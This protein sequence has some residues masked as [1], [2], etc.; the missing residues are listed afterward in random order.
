MYSKGLKTGFV[1]VLLTLAFMPIKAQPFQ[2]EARLDTNR[3][4]IGDQIHLY[5]MLNQP[6]TAR[7]E[8]PRWQQRISAEVEVIKSFP[9]DTLRKGQEE[10][11]TVRQ[12]YLITSFDSGAVKIPPVSFLYK[13]RRGLDSVLTAPL[14]LYVETVRVD[15]TQNIFGIKGPFGAPLSWS[16][17]LPWILGA[18][19][20]GLILWAV[21]YVLRRRKKQ[22]PL[23]K[24]RK[25][26]EPAHEYA[27]RELD[28]LK[29]D[30]LWQ[31]DQIKAYYT[32]LT[33]I[34]RTYLWMRYGIKTLERTTE[35]ILSSLNNSEMDDQAAFSLLA[36]NLRFADLVKF[37]RMHPAPRENEASLQQAYDFVHTTKHIPEDQEQ[38]KGDDD[39]QAGQEQESNTKEE[40]GQ[41]S[42]Q[43]IKTDQ[44][45]R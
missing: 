16:E 27:L 38:E 17:M 6:E 1:I 8:F 7:V 20:L 34:L 33:E 21:I 10:G 11:I 22:E 24:A 4:R 19:A 26:K 39:Q 37:A 15:T 29:E 5:L 9:R 13:D 36:D 44:G 12:R 35:E 43:D 30:R 28:R 42:T 2:A 3:M 31:N 40:K 18:I 23:L 41:E 45:A 32:R 25:P 14:S